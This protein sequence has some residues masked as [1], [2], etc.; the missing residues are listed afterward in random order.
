MAAAEWGGA[1]TDTQPQLAV[2]Q[3]FVEHCTAQQISLSWGRGVWR[4]M[5]AP[6]VREVV[7]HSLIPCAGRRQAAT[8]RLG[9]VPHRRP[10][11]RASPLDELP[12]L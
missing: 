12:R 10:A 11:A 7:G 8:R 3:Q 5:E 6:A 2:A 1:H 4:Q 9:S